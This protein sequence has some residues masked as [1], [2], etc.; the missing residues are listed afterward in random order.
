MEYCRECGIEMDGEICEYCGWSKVTNMK[1]DHK[2]IHKRPSKKYRP[3]L[4]FLGKPIVLVS[5]VVIFIV[6]RLIWEII[7]V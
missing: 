6:I 1:E 3:I 7:I 2:Y 4:D 5:I